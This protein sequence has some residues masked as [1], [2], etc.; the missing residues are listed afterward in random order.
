MKYIV[1]KL[2]FLVINLILFSNGKL[3]SQQQINNAGFESWE[4]IRSEVFEPVHWNSIKNTDGGMATNRMAPNVV[5]RDIV[6]H[7]GNNALKLVNT[8]TMGIIANGILTNGAIHGNIDKEK[9]Y[10]YTDTTDT[11]FSTAFT[12]RPDSITG[13]YKYAPKENDSAMVVIL[14]HDNYVTMPDHGTKSNWVGGVKV[15]LGA[16]PVDSWARFSAPL[17]YVK[18]TPPKYILMAL[19]AGNRKNA[20]EGSVAYFDDLKLIYNK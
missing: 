16:T 5:F 20:V 15:M 13:W 17:W 18:D 1:L 2:C 6:S 19:S 9:S 12:S 11:K 4:E 14:L 7:S 10:V 8:S 3:F